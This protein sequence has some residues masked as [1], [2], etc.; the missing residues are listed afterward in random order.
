MVAEADDDLVQ[1]VVVGLF[2][3]GGEGEVSGEEFG[4]GVVLLEPQEESGGC[5]AW[6]GAVEAAGVIS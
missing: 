3:D 2:D 4:G 1:G 5:R 6:E